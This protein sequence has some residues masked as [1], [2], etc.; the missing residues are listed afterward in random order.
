VTSPAV[1]RAVVIGLDGATWSVLQPLIEDG[2]MPALAALLD[3]SAW[4][5]LRST[6]PPYTPP[7]WTTAATG[8]NPGRHG[9]FGFVQG[10]ADPRLSHWGMV[11]SPAIWR[12]LERVGRTVGLFHLPLTYPPPP[13]QGWAVGAVW[14]PTAQ[15]ITGFTYPRNLESEIRELAL[16]YAPASGVELFED[17]RDP[18]LADRVTATLRLRRV[19]LADLLERRP[20][21]LVWAV[22]EAPDRLHH[23]YYKYLD[24]VEPLASTPGAQE[25]RAAVRGAFSELDKIVRLLDDFA[26]S[27]GVAFVCSDH[28]ATGWHGYIYGNRLLAE[29][30]LLKLR[31][32]GRAMG[33]IGVSRLGG[34]A[35]RVL[36]DRV[37]YRVRRRVQSMTDPAGT[38][39][40]TARL[41][42]QGF[43]LN[44]AGREPDG[45]LPPER[46]AETLGRLS[47]V[48]R[49]AQAPSGQPFFEAVHHRQDLY[50]GPSAEEAPDLI[51][52]P[53]GS[54]WEV[55]DAMGERRL[56]RDFSFLPLGCHHPEGVIA[57]R[58]PGVA[59]SS[60]IRAD[61]VDVT[62]TILYAMDV[63]VPEGLDGQVRRDLFGP[64]APAAASMPAEEPASVERETPYTAEQEAAITK[65][66]TDLGYLG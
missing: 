49:D 37:S 65:Y 56:V 32:A 62:P 36:S 19:I 60:G 34:L 29:A 39:A 48:L 61:I 3:R 2:A 5:T 7:A 9:I 64:A 58:A 13:V 33:A 25:I 50:Q 63:P 43:S 40:Y 53:T 44:L 4:G 18:G 1:R 22:L 21:D 52:E 8:V 35:R 59:A 57:V 24:P 30:G 41:G 10:R 45:T 42:S 14:M 47:R 16:E 15:G 17:W 26:G 27:G 54:R 12:Y 23:A 11:R 20:V 55:N 51:V 38:V 28:G 66:L 6:I 31:P 46:A